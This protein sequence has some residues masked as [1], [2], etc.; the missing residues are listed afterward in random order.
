MLAVPVLL[1]TKFTRSLLRD[2]HRMS[3]PSTFKLWLAGD[4]VHARIR[5]PRMGLG[6]QQFA[7]NRHLQTKHYAGLTFCTSFSPVHSRSSVSG[8]RVRAH[9]EA[10]GL[11]RE[12]LAD[13]I[14]QDV[15][16]VFALENGERKVS[17]DELWDLCQ[18]LDVQP[19]VLVESQAHRA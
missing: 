8:T 6:R 5:V 17:A 13:L 19:H 1:K 9:R 16:F 3:S 11:S 7:S 4:R 2:K 14:G 12:L 10:T 15:E 18:A